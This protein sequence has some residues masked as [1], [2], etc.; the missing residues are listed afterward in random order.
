MAGERHGNGMGASWARH[1]MCESA[2]NVPRIF[3]A[4]R[5]YYL[6][7]ITGNTLLL[8]TVLV[9]ISFMTDANITCPYLKTLRQMG[10][11]IMNYGRCMC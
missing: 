9:H 2:F 5:C 1:A 3:A 8:V 7:T 10:C 6:F 11:K 4:D